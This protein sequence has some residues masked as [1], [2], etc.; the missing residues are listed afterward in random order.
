MGKR[1]P[2]KEVINRKNDGTITASQSPSTAPFFSKRRR[3][4]QNEQA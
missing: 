3:M 2:A 4:K 1:P